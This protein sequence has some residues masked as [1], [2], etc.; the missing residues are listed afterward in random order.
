MIDLVN[1]SRLVQLR[2]LL[3]Q[4]ATAID[5]QPGARDLASLS[6]QYRETLV[7]I[8]EI[9]GKVNDGDEISEILQSRKNA[10]LAGAVRKNR[11]SI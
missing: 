7:E 6:K 10:R 9:E 3:E 2:A 4:L 5:E 11:T 1:E 8:E